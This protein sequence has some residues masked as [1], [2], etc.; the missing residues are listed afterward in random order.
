MTHD[1]ST[2]TPRKSF[3]YNALSRAWVCECG[4]KF[5]IPAEG[6]YRFKPVLDH[7]CPE[8]DHE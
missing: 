8:E 7:R 3:T 1:P 5:A 2:F 4:A 6:A